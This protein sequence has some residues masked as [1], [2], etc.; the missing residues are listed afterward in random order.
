MRCPVC[1]QESS[2]IWESV[3]GI[4][5]G[6]CFRGLYIC[7]RCGHFKASGTERNGNRTL[8]QW[9]PCCPEHGHDTVL[10]ARC[11]GWNDTEWLCS[12]CS[13]RMA[14][15]DGRLVTT[16]KPRGRPVPVVDASLLMVQER[17]RLGGLP[18]D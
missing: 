7:H 9:H 4:N 1:N 2:K 13:R 15:Q 17:G 14:I 3:T 5:G 6:Q 12:A 18:H 10:L 11:D 8:I 16:W